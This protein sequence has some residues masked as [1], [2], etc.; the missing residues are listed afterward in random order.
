MRRSHDRE[1]ALGRD[2]EEVEVAGLHP[3]TDRVARV[4]PAVGSREHREPLVA[5]R[6]HPD[7][8]LP[9]EHLDER[10]TAVDRTDQPAPS[11]QSRAC[12]GR[13]PT[14]TSPARRRGAHPGVFDRQGEVAAAQR[15]PAVRRA[16]PSVAKLIE[17]LPMNPATNTFAG[18]S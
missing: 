15:Q 2:V 1:R 5:A 6:V 14:I 7:Q 17:G 18:C 8:G 13:I 4:D 10:R 16:T 9:A 3:E 12:S 11:R